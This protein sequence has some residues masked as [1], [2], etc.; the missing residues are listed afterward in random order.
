MTMQSPLPPATRVASSSRSA[1]VLFSLPILM[2]QMGCGGDR[3]VDTRTG[4]PSETI[5][6]TEVPAA[7]SAAARL[8]VDSF[9]VREIGAAS[10]DYMYVP[11][12]R[13]REAGS[14]AN[15]TVLALRVKVPGVV[16]APTCNTSIIMAPG[17]SKD[18][19]E[20]HYGDYSYYTNSTVRATE[21]TATLLL[22][23]SDG[24]G[25]GRTIE[26]TGA[27]VRDTL[28]TPYT[29]GTFSWQCSP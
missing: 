22:K 25:S 10:G 15:A 4:A 21:P 7:P 18:L 16:D 2:A 27:I 14:G 8:V 6:V 29:G 9:R 11:E 28:P 20:L 24:V 3:A 12:L 13:V 5:P 17:S 1:C 19:I 26:A 23:V